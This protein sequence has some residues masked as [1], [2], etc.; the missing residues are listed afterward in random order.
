L[1]ELKSFV[2]KIVAGGLLFSPLAISAVEPGAKVTST[3]ASNPNL[4]SPTDGALLPML[5]ALIAI[6]VVIYVTAWVAKKFNLTPHQSNHMKT[7]TSLSLGGRERIVI[8]EIQQ[9][10]YAIG[11]TPHSV[12]TLF[13]LDENIAP[14]SFSVPNNK[15][16]NKLTELLNNELPKTKKN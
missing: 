2:K 16:L 5:M 14:S 8:I 9:Q 12:N 3:V 10:Q 6:I 13:K 1:K 4:S 15:L 11:V 7:I